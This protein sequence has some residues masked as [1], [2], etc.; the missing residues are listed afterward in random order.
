MGIYRADAGGINPRFPD[1]FEDRMSTAVEPIV[2][3]AGV[4]RRERGDEL[5]AWSLWAGAATTALL[6]FFTIYGAAVDAGFLGRMGYWASVPVPLLAGAVLMLVRILRARVDAHP[7]VIAGALVAAVFGVMYLHSAKYYP[8]IS[9]PA[10][11]VIVS[12]Y[13]IHLS[14][15]LVMA[16]FVWAKSDRF[17]AVAAKPLLPAAGAALLVWSV[18]LFAPLFITPHLPRFDRTLPTFEP[19]NGHGYRDIEWNARPAPG[20]TRVLL[21]GDSFT[22]GLGVARGERFTDQVREKRSDLEVLNAGAL[23]KDFRHY[24]EDYRDKLRG[25]KAKRVVVVYNLNDLDF[26]EF[27]DPLPAAGPVELYQK[28]FRATFLGD[29]L[30]WRVLYGLRTRGKGD[31]IDTLYVPDR[32]AV[33]DEVLGKFH[34]AVAA[35]GGELRLIVFPVMNGFADYPYRGHHES[36]LSRCRKRGIACTDLLPVFEQG[37]VPAERLWVSAYDAHPNAAANAMAAPAVAEFVGRHL[38]KDER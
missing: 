15:V 6:V 37:G 29:W 31:F 4:Q 25:L 2:E 19:P 13:R 33:F 38:P 18:E 14:T 10:C 27:P 11:H 23:G 34:E 5:A 7:I 1:C 35:D 32:L 21:M 9:S 24:F 28:L 17:G 20:K 36:I 22:Y 12:L 26:P 3:D 8:F 30:Y 16:V